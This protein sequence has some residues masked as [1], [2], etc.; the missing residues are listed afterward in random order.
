MVGRERE[1]ERGRERDENKLARQHVDVDEVEKVVK[2]ELV[3]CERNQLCDVLI[4]IRRR[5]YFK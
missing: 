5:K 3:H 1:R 2:S 4:S